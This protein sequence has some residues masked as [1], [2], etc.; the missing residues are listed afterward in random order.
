MVKVFNDNDC[1]YKI[2]Q[3]T[4]MIKAMITDF[5]DIDCDCK[6]LCKIT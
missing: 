2:V 3:W 4:L 1:N 6:K 5:H